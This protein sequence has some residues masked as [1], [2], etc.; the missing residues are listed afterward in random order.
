MQARHSVLVIT[1]PAPHS[2]AYL[3]QAGRQNPPGSQSPMAVTSHVLAGTIPNP[4]RAGLV[5]VTTFR[6]YQRYAREAT[7]AIT[8]LHLPS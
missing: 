1:V 7:P 2:N 8:A 4:I 3:R 5:S 6:F